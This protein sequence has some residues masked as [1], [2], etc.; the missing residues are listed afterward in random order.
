MKTRIL[1]TLAVTALAV[2]VTFSATAGETDT[3]NPVTARTKVIIE[4]DVVRLGD[5]FTN[6]GELAD[7]A[8]AYAPEPGSRAVFDIKWLY[9]VAKA[10]K[11][12]WRPLSRKVSVSV[13]RDAQVIGREEIAD[14]IRGALIDKGADRDLLIE[15]SNRSLRL[16]VPT[17]KAA[18]VGVE[19]ITYDQRTRRFTAI[20][21][22]PADDP[23]A[24]RIRVTGQAHKMIEV[25]VLVRRI[26][27]GE[28]IGEHDIKWRPMRAGRVAADVVM[29]AEDLLG[30]TAR[31]GALRDDQP[32][33]NRDIRRPL[34]VKKGS[35][36]TMYMKV[37]NMTLSSKGR[38]LENGS[39]GDAITISNSQTNTIVEAV[40]IGAG[41]VS[42]VPVARHFKLAQAN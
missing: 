29:A 24:K 21:S 10:Y 18:L 26:Q 41:R 6:T 19:D 7:K 38:A 8:I 1:T 30:K 35:L 12:K 17:D 28:I 37:P 34:L 39:D 16:Y 22:A 11:L 27:K 42:V 14:H 15:I 20:V 9:R 32:I 25:P 36:V 31:R 5:L 13:Q 3:A 4:G 33:R 40:V 2:A 23:S